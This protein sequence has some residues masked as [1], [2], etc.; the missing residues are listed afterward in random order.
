M[1]RARTGSVGDLVGCAFTIERDERDGGVLVPPLL[2]QPL[3]EN[4]MRH[5]IEPNPQ[6]GEIR[7]TATLVDTRLRITVTDSG[8]PSTTSTPGT[9]R[10]RD[11]TCRE[12]DLRSYAVAARAS[13]S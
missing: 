1:R 5:G 8:S 11:S 6:P 10:G 12:I 3:V 2:L 13:R 7:V 9:G 4:A